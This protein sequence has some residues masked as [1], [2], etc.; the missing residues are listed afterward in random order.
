[1]PPVFR[2]RTAP[3]MPCLSRLASPSAFS[4]LCGRRSPRRV[5]FAGNDGHFTRK[6]SGPKAK[7][8]CPVNRHRRT[9]HNAVA[10]VTAMREGRF[11]NA[12]RTSFRRRRDPGYSGI[13][14]VVRRRRQEHGRDLRESRPR[15]SDADVLL[16]SHALAG[17]PARSIAACA[18]RL[19]RTAWASYRACR[20]DLQI[21]TPSGAAPD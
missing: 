19:V 2:C 10:P 12:L 1:M 3:G 6:P 11:E 21:P 4:R 8:T 17:K 5:A 9:H 18:A 16:Q 14:A 15:S 13:C 20:P 7:T